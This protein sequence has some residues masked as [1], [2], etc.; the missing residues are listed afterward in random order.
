MLWRQNFV[1][2]MRVNRENLTMQSLRQ[3]N[4][5]FHPQG[6]ARGCQYQ[7]LSRLRKE[8]RTV[9]CLEI[10]FPIQDLPQDA[11]GRGKQTK[12][13]YIEIIK[14][15]VIFIWLDCKLKLFI[16]LYFKVLTHIWDNVLK[17]L[18]SYNLRHFLDRISILFCWLIWPA[19]CREWAFP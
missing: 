2:I 16:K 11:S 1:A 4:V 15:Y 12:P 5:S 9:F 10:M 13:L 14:N 6:D 3:V 17:I 8:G 18:I 7:L 19:W